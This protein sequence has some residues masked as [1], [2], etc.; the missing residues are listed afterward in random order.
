MEISP[1]ELE[2]W[3]WAKANRASV[4]M[5][6]EHFDICLNTAHDVYQKGGAYDRSQEQCQGGI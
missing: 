4:I 5:T 1:A 6:A 3:D 2:I